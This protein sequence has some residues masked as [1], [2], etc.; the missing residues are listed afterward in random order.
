MINYFAYGSNISE[1]RMRAERNVNFISRKFA[2]LENYKLV[3][4][5]VSKKNSQ[6]GFA[7]VV[8]SEGDDV[9]GALYELNDSDIGIIDRF[10][11]A[12]SNPSHYFRKNVNVICDG[13]IVNAIVYVA[14]P[15][16]IRENINPDKNYLNYI[17]AGNDIFSS[18][19]YERLKLTKTLD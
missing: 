6:L 15:I 18:D 4:N 7:N 14:N 16:M 3:F 12:N 2:I 17:L 8:E 13:K 1:Y 9:E 10:E 5:K 11:G 19:Y